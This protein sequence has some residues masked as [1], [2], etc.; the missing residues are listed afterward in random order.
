MSESSKFDP[1]SRGGRY[2]L[3]NY[4][5]WK[6]DY[7]LKIRELN[8]RQLRND[9]QKEDEIED[10][11]DELIRAT[12]RKPRRDLKMN[13]ELDEVENDICALAA[14]VDH[15]QHGGRRSLP[16]YRNKRESIEKLAE[17]ESAGAGLE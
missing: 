10:L 14:Q 16:N 12:K 4:Q 11:V 8:S 7:I 15:L 17:K 3:L 9:R 13:A 6:R 1:E 2:R 5:K